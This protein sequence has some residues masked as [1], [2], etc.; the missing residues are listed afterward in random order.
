MRPEQSLVRGRFCTTAK[1][2]ALWITRFFW[3]LGIPVGLS[4]CEP[5]NCC[6]YSFCIFFSSGSGNLSHT[7]AD[8]YSVENLRGLSSDPP[9]L[10]VHLSPLW[11]S[12]FVNSSRLACLDFCSVSW[13]GGDHSPAAVQEESWDV[14]GA[15][16]VP[17]F[18]GSRGRAIT[19]WCL[20][21]GICWFVYIVWSCSCS[22][23]IVN[24][25]PVTAS[26]LEGEVSRLLFEPIENQFSETGLF[27]LPLFISFSLRLDPGPLKRL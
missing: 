15:L 17:V 11:Y 4:V 26:W 27:S 21:S 19:G 13:S 1:A 2:N 25:F 9:D 22:A 24:L 10:S 14:V 16:F 5:G 7:Y 3:Q 8:W 23:G 6:L 12:A 18:Q 20:I